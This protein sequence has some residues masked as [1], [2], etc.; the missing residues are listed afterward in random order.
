[1]RRSA[2]LRLGTNATRS[3]STNAVGIYPVCPRSAPYLPK[4]LP[5]DREQ[6]VTKDIICDCLAESRAVVRRR[7]EMNAREH[8]SI[9]DLLQ[10]RG[11][12]RKVTHHSCHTVGG[13][14]ELSVFSEVI[15]KNRGGSRADAGVRRR[16]VR[17]GRCWKQR[18]P[19]RI[20][21]SVGIPVRPGELNG[22]DRP[23]EIIGVLG[24]PTANKGVRDTDVTSASNRAF[25]DKVKWRSE[26]SVI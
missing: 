3:T 10:S 22:C 5:I 20:G 19:A 26:D 2:L 1:M 23:P 14:A 18:G 17:E 15:R 11:E 4:A 13:D 21:R 7:A 24:I 6:R 12:A 16:V 8:T 9:L 25:S